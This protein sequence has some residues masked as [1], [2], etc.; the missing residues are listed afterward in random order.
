VANAT[1]EEVRTFGAFLTPGGEH[2]YGE[3]LGLENESG[4]PM[5]RRLREPSWLSLEP[6]EGAPQPL[7]ELQ[8][9]VPVAPGKIIAVGRN[10]HAHAKERGADVPSSPLTW[11]KAPTSLLA[12]LGAIELPYPQHKVDFEAEL[13]IV[14]GRPAKNVTL[15][16]AAQYI[17]GYTAS[18]DISDR[19]IQDAEKQFARAKSFD[20]FTPIG[21]FVY[22]GLGPD[23]LAITLR[24]NGE[25]RQNGRTGEMIFSA[26]EIVSFCSQ[27]TTLQA[28]D[29]ILTGTPAGVGP[30]KDGDVLETRI[31]PFAPLVVRVRDASSL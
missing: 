20:T 28:G 23:D 1:V 7:A 19:P 14:I 18:L 31:G 24:Q 22:S 15:A 6:A 21:P 26:A 17:F 30:I 12:H 9:G 5:V 29:V 16:D 11:L 8:A 2:F 25:L 13:A 3:V 10:Y 27:G 4:A